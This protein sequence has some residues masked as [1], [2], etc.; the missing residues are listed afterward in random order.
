MHGEMGPGNS[1]N[2]PRGHQRSH[3]A[4]R[5]LLEVLAAD[6]ERVFWPSAVFE[7]AALVPPEGFQE[8]EL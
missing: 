3:V 4:I 6:N 5:E 2:I 7:L 8:K 1:V